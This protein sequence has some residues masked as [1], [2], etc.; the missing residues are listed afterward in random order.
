M[1]GKRAKVAG[2]PT[3]TLIFPGILGQTTFAIAELWVA[4]VPKWRVAA[5]KLDGDGVREIA[6]CCKSLLR[7]RVTPMGFEPESRP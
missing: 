2:D 4:R 7:E 1:C 5:A 6:T 3:K